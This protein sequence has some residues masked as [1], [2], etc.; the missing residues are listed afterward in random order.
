MRRHRLYTELALETGAEITLDD[1]QGHYLRHVMR[2]QGGDPVCLFNGR[3][4]EYEAEIIR[5]ARSGGLCRVG[6]HIDVDREMP[7]KVHIIQAASRNEKIE[8]VLQKGTELGTASFQ[9]IVSERSALKLAGE[10]RAARLH[11]WRRIIVEAAEQSG[12]TRIPPLHWRE[13][14]AE[15]CV[16]GTGY[17]LHPS[18][19]LAWSEARD[20]IAAAS[21]LS[22]VI[23]PE[24]G[25]GSRD[26]QALAEMDCLALAFGPL[27]MRTETAAPALLAAIQA[28]H[29]G[30]P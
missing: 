16:R 6:K 29:G 26:L 20:R 18:A 7:C 24:G 11:R 27:I 19:E 2:L 21:E 5:L 13:S 30:K 22:L 12:R 3:G 23:G 1:E 17:A 9:I 14:L 8:A 28:V 15:I 25:L 4:G 10:K